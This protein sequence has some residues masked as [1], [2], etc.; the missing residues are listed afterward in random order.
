M[1]SPD[2][3]P[4]LSDTVFSSH[5]AFNHLLSA[6]DTMSFKYWVNEAMPEEVAY[7]YVCIPH[8]PGFWD[9]VVVG[10]RP[11]PRT[12]K[13]IGPDDCLP[14][15]FNVSLQ[16]YRFHWC[17]FVLKKQ[18]ILTMWCTSLPRG[19]QSKVV[20][21]VDNTLTNLTSSNEFRRMVFYLCRWFTAQYVSPQDRPLNLVLD[22]K[23]SEGATLVHVIALL[24]SRI[25]METVTP[26]LARQPAQDDSNDCFRDV[27]SIFTCPSDGN[28]GGN[29]IDIV[30]EFSSYHHSGNDVIGLTR[31]C[32]T[33]EY[34][35]SL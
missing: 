10:T 9:H 4:G 7:R 11:L 16:S 13:L 14:R 2:N 25:G 15:L 28:S 22:C 1:T 20:T 34:Y 8:V 35:R 27:N 30:E 32:T 21:V 18:I 29:Y 23:P 12:D 26:H 3:V 17:C 5:A 19:G 6:N 24:A 33:T 31:M